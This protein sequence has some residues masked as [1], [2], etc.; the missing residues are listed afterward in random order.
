[1]INLRP[2]TP[3][4]DTAVLDEAIQLFACHPE[5]DSIRAVRPAHKTPYKIWL[6]RDDGLMSPLFER[7]NECNE[8]YNL[9]S[10][11]LPK[12]VVQDGYFDI[13]RTSTILEKIDHGVGGNAFHML[14]T[15]K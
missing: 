11:L 3:L 1:V 15:K 13:T 2:T 8:P 14:P 6:L 5:I 9:P 7:F 10:Q 12:V 4:R